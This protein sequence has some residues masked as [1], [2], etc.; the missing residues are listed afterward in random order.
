V[1]GKYDIQQLYGISPAE[2]G[3]IW[4]AQGGRCNICGKPLRHRFKPD[5]HPGQVAAVDHDHGVAKRGKHKRASIRGLLCTY[6]CNKFL[7]KFWTPAKLEAAARHCRDFP[8][9]R[10]LDAA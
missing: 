7:Y 2:W 8:A 1:G 3:A 10:V 6:P 5:A 9:Q 4:E